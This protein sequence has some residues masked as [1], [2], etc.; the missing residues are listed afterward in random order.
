MVLR[1]GPARRP[2]SRHESAGLAG[3]CGLKGTRANSRVSPGRCD[4]GYGATHF[5]QVPDAKSRAVYNNNNNRN[6]VC[7]VWGPLDGREARTGN[8]D[9]D[10]AYDYAGDTY[11]FYMNR[12]NRDSIDGAGYDHHL[13]SQI[14]LPDSSTTCPYPNAFWNGTQMVYG[15]GYALGDDVSAM[16]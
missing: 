12:H 10:K 8:G 1:P 16:S 13:N 6:M 9:V 15:D 2:R 7:R 3:G 5:N 4:D 14:L 11:D